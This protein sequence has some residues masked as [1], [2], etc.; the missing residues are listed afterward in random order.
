MLTELTRQL[1]TLLADAGCAAYAADAVPPDAAFPFVTFS[2]RPAASLHALGQ[3]TLTGWIRGPGC[4]AARLALA[5]QLL[6]IVPPG[7]LKLPLD[8]GLAVLHRGDRLNVEWPEAPGALGCMVKHGLRLI[9][10][11][12]DD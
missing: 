1:V 12:A 5:D 3:V 10:G 11:A 7:G 4:H 6:K 2:I 9:G 8:D